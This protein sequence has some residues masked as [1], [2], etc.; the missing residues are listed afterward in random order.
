M[1]LIHH[2]CRRRWSYGFV[3]LCFARARADTPTLTAEEIEQASVVIPRSMIAAV[4]V[5]G[6]LGFAMFI[7]TLFCLGNPDDALNTPTGYPFIEVFRNAT[8]NNAGA[9]AL[10]SLPGSHL[11]MQLGFFLTVTGCNHHHDVHI[12]LCCNPRDCFEDD[13]GFCQGER[14]TGGNYTSKGGL[15][16]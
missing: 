14:C 13:M 2:R 5:N 6:V 10:V 12:C 11:P 1:R 3:S 7:A 4:V 9:T 16:L 8:G 15:S